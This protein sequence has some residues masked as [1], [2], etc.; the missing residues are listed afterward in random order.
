MNDVVDDPTET[1]TASPVEYVEDDAALKAALEHERN[2][3]KRR[4]M[5]AFP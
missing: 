4:L 5:T 2:Q 3:T 1:W